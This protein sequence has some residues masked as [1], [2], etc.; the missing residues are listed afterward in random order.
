MVGFRVRLSLL[1]FS[2]ENRKRNPSDRVVH[3]CLE[4]LEAKHGKPVWGKHLLW[5]HSAGAEFRYDHS[6]HTILRKTY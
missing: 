5:N 4:G 3:G 1:C 6:F 2:E